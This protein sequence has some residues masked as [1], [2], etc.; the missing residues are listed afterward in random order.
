MIYWP[1]LVLRSG[2]SGATF[3]QFVYDIRFEKY[4]FTCAVKTSEALSRSGPIDVQPLAPTC[5][6]PRGT[7]NLFHESVD[8]S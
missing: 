5:L 4:R 7:A 1:R 2:G 3:N 6:E 8:R